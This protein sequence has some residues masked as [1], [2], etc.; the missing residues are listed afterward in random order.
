MAK[1]STPAPRTAPGVSARRPS[2]SRGRSR[3]RDGS[4]SRTR[5]RSRRS[6]RAVGKAA[7]S[8]RVKRARRRMTSRAMRRSRGWVRHCSSTYLPVLK[9]AAKQVEEMLKAFDS[10]SI[11][12]E[13]SV[14]DLTV[15]LSSRPNPFGKV[16]IGENSNFFA[17]AHRHP[18]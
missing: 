16:P 8:R 17:R 1:F 13:R 4:S 18:A 5:N 14:E 15:A 3:S 2:R 9:A 12:I 11:N 6:R 7:G 10:S